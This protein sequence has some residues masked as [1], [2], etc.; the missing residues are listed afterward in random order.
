MHVPAVLIL[1]A[2]LLIAADDPKE[3]AKKELGQFQG[4]WTAASVQYNGKDYAEG[5]GKIR[6]VFKGDQVSVEASDKI[7]KEYA[8]LV[9][10]LDP[11]TNPHC[12]DI[13]VAAGV[14][15]DVVIEGIYELK[16]DELRLCAK[17]FGKDRPNQFESTDGSS[18][19]LVVL[20][21]DKP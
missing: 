15:K 21:K 9:F 11:S 16:G 1:T 8:R 12:V 6:F 18:I 10:K 19:A 7:K 2:G 17:V 5:A 20:K 3:A 4:S 13:T 14:Q